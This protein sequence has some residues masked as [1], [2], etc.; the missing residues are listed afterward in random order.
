MITFRS[1][2]R[3][4]AWLSAMVLAA[5][6][7]GCGDGI[8]GGDDNDGAGAGAGTPT[9][10]GAGTGVGGLGRGPAPVNLG[11]AGTFVILAESAI[12]NVPTSA[13]T[14]DVGLSPATGANIGLT[15]AQ[16]T[17]TIYSADAAGPLPCVVTDAVLL[18][19]AIGAK[20]TAYTNATGR[21]ADYTELGAG[22][23]SGLNLGPAT[24]NWGTGVLIA[25]NLTLTGGPNDGLDLP[26]RAGF[27]RQSRRADCF[28][29]WRAA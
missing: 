3:P 21:P 20:D 14:G 11:A 2:I 19:A 28:G 8:F 10:A 23:I 18:T 25:S 7:S 24:Y 27:G 22:N 9:A 6:M 16:V 29:R 1:S 5:V 26:D 17:G 12:T 4:L 15:C 13:V